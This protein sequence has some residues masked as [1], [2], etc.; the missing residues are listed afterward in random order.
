MDGLLLPMILLAATD[1]PNQKALFRQILPAIIPGPPSQ[2]LVLATISAK[3]QIKSEAE[4]EQSLVKAAIDAGELE[5]ADLVNFPALDAAFK[6]VPASIQPTLFSTARAG[7][8]R[9][10]GGDGT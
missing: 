10:R 3:Q 1:K 4:I 2:R 5:P 7:G 8:R 9:K 6:R